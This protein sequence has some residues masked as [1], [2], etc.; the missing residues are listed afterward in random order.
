MQNVERVTF[1]AIGTIWNI[2][3]SIPSGVKKSDVLLAI[4]KRIV[5][6]DESY[7]RFRKD[8]WVFNMFKKPGTYSVPPDFEKM[9]EVYLKLYGVTDGLF[10]PAIGNLLREAGYDEDYSLMPKKLHEPPRINTVLSFEGNKLTTHI[11][12]VLDFGAAGKGYL[13]DLVS[14]IIKSF[15]VEHFC[16][17]AG[18]DI[19]YYSQDKK[20]IRVGLENPLDTSQVI[21][22]AEFHNKSICGSAGNRRAWGKFH[23]IINPL[24]QKS[25]DEILAVWVVADTALIADAMSTALFLKPTDEVAAAY[26]CEHLILFEDFSTKKSK[27]FPAEL[28]TARV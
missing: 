3:I 11:P 28:F 7:S 4:K 2:E 16:I 17:D 6:F 19:Y 15:K 14:E 27:D 23:H 24:T 5:L 26:I 1:E 18:R 25:P 22:V 9:F 8:S 13:I 21:G 20:N 12:V 10:T